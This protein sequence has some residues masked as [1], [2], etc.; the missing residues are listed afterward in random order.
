MC[1]I[2]TGGVRFRLLK[3]LTKTKFI[4]KDIYKNNKEK[5]D[6]SLGSLIED[7]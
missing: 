2:I 1:G 3:V 6:S 4:V 5:K 7:K